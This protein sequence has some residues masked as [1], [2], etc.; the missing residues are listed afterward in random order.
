MGKEQMY[1]QK[2]GKDPP[3]RRTTPS[4]NPAEEQRDSEARSREFSGRADL[5]L[6]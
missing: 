2:A 1:R 6:K 5:V 3:G 4:E